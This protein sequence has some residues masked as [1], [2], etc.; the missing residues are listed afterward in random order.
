MRGMESAS[1]ALYNAKLIRGFF[2][3]PIW[4]GSSTLS[5]LL[6]CRRC[7]GSGCI[8]RKLFRL[9]SSTVS[10]RKPAPSPLAIATP[11]PSCVVALSKVSMV[12]SSVAKSACLTEKAV[13]CTYLPRSSS[14]ATVSSE[15]RFLCEFRSEVHGREESYVRA[16]RWWCDSPMSGV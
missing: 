12:S 7:Y 13:Q 10:A 3:L 8:H 14:E 11:S 15:L 6:R 1:D 5:L 9:A 2:H 4:A 16:I